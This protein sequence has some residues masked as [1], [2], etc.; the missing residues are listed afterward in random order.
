METELTPMEIVEMDVTLLL[1]QPSV[2]AMKSTLTQD[3][4]YK[5]VRYLQLHPLYGDRIQLAQIALLMSAFMGSK[6]SKF[7]DFYTNKHPEP[8]KPQE[9]VS[10]QQQNQNLD[11]YIRSVYT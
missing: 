4:F 2:H 1:G 8:D 9:E 5:W 7:E 6:D 3:E 10:K 11:Q